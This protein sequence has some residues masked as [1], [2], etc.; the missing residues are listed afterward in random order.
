MEVASR[1]GNVFGG[2]P[3]VVT[4]EDDCLEEDYEIIC[5]LADKSTEG[6]YIDSRRAV[7]PSPPMRRT[8]YVPFDFYVSNGTTTIYQ[9][10]SRYQACKFIYAEKMCIYTLICMPLMNVV[11]LEDR[12]DITILNG[13]NEE[14]VLFDKNDQITIRWPR[15]IVPYVDAD[16]YRVDLISYIQDLQTGE[17]VEYEF[18]ARD[19]PNSGNFNAIISDFK[20][21]PSN[22][23]S[24]VPVL[25]QVATQLSFKG[26]TTYPPVYSKWS[27]TIYI[28]FNDSK[29]SCEVWLSS[30]D[31]SIGNRLLQQLPPCPRTLAQANLV[32]SGFDRDIIHPLFLE[33]YHS[34]SQ[35]CFRQRNVQ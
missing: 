14:V 25:F 3:I 10:G 35:V 18:L 12:S 4:L 2:T 17:W 30:E 16:S 13:N 32:N 9:G 8:G 33:F 21:L 23:N 34:K 29:L 22:V 24:V 28:E 6:L 15:D 27:L 7:C 11:F 1:F 19:A 26:Q 31:P 20:D 5:T